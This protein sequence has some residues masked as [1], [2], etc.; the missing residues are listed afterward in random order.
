M[1]I[2]EIESIVE[3]LLSRVRALETKLSEIAAK[4]AAKE[5]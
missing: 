1:N 2:K 3:E 4:Y 5:E